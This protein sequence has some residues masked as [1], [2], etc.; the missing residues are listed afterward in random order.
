LAEVYS[1]PLDWTLFVE[2][3]FGEVEFFGNN[4]GNFAPNS[5]AFERTEGENRKSDVFR[6]K[7]RSG[8]PPR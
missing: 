1:N 3:R 4:F 5:I 7:S 2:Q 6:L 8:A